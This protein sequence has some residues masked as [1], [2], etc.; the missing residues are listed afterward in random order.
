MIAAGVDNRAFGGSAQVV[1]IDGDGNAL[2]AIELP[3]PPT[4]VNAT[5]STLLVTTSQELLRFA[6]T[7]TSEV[8]SAETTCT[9]ISPALQSPVNEDPRR[10]LRVEAFATLPPGTTLEISY[11]T[12]DDPNVRDEA[13]RIVNDPSVPAS[14]RLNRLRDHLGDWK[15]PL[16]LPGSDVLVADSPV[17]L[18]APLFDVRNPYL[19]VSVRLTAAPGS[20]MPELLAS[21]VCFTLAAP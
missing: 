17:P 4:G 5:A 19:W 11:A 9:F 10:W 3:A 12:T 6:P 21:F 8:V 15:A 13:E 2:G 20:M 16:V 1:C 14:R 7:G 18:A